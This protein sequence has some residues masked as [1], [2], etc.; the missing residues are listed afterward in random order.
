MARS[1]TSTLP[2]HSS[3]PSPREKSNDFCANTPII[4]PRDTGMT[5]VGSHKSIPTHHTT[6]FITAFH[7][8]ACKLSSL[9]SV[10]RR[11]LKDIAHGVKPNAKAQGS[12]DRSVPWSAKLGICY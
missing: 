2:P 6:F 1:D 9:M 12:D 10:F 3:P 4:P 7:F 5:N 11:F 8:S